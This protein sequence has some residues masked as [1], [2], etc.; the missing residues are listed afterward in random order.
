MRTALVFGLP[1]VAAVYA[2]RTWVV[3]A[4]PAHIATVGSFAITKDMLL[5]LLFAVL[6]IF[7]SASMIRKSKGGQDVEQ[8]GGY[9]YPVLIGQGLF[10]GTLT[11]LIGAG[12][13]FL[14]IPALVNLLKMPMKKAVGTSLVIIAINSGTGFLFSLSR[15]VI[16][17]P[18]L[19]SVAAI[20][21]GGILAG[22]MLAARI[23]GKKLKPAFGWFVL[24]MGV[25]ILIKETLLK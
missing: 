20:A 3:P 6:M 1:S 4:I 13:G 14:I 18:L 16:N 12:G 7:A 19:L 22:S 8:Q 17:W 11:G 25:Y 15:T 23:D 24:I 2:T 21:I 9:N 5:M 10:V